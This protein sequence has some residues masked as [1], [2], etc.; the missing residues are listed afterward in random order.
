M[1]TAT[2]LRTNWSG[3]YEYQA[4]VLHEPR[5][6]EELEQI[7]ARAD[8]IRALGSRHSFN[9]IADSEGEQVSLTHLGAMELDEASRTVTV[10]GGVTHAK[11]APWLQD[12]GYALHNL[13][14][15]PHITAA[16]AVQTATH[17]SGLKLGNL[18]TAVT[19]VDL[20]TARGELLR[21][22]REAQ[23]EQFEGM[24]V[25]LGSLGIAASLKLR[26]EPAFFVSQRV[27]EHLP[28]AALQTR[29]R[30][31]YAS[32]YSVSL[33]TDWNPDTVSQVWV[34]SRAGVDE[35]AGSQALMRELGSR[36]AERE[37]HP[38]PG[39]DA[40]N[41]TPQMGVP[42]PWHERLPHFRADFQPSS[43]DEL[44]TEY[45]IPFERGWEAIQAVAALG[46]R[47][48]PLLFV[49]ELRAIAADAL[50]LSPAY[51]R[52]SLAFHFTWKLDWPRVREIL[53]EIEQAL[54]PFDAR[55]HWGKMF[56]REWAAVAALYPEMERF[57][58]LRVKLDPRGKFRNE[59]TAFL[60]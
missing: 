43:G 20:V 44:Q 15:L 51:G 28:L 40:G 34:K 59:T 22:S 60:G 25:A 8:R 21:L 10:G 50:W 55:P 23:G 35:E 31:V 30:D 36:P 16:G 52:E 41:C 37:S 47:I 5:S 42:G 14:S 45:F 6:L 3:N 7:I 26:V 9:G 39:H 13:A 54:A 49:S 27:Y 18:A 48:R 58:G 46:E 29:L 38:L 1:A 17:G 2:A 33:F 53:P 24:V 12:R 56:T 32:G 57:R 11:L 4:R 19:A